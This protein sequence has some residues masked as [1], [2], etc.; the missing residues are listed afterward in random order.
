MVKA[1]DDMGFTSPGCLAH[2]LQLVVHDGVLSQRAVLDVLSICRRI[3]GH[4]KHSSLACGSLRKIQANLGLPIHTLKQDVPTRWNSTY[5]MLTSILEQKLALA[6]YATENSIPN[7]TSHQL[8]LVSKVVTVLAPVEEITQMISTEVAPVSVLIPLVRGLMKTLEKHHIN[9]SGVRTMKGEMLVSLKRRFADMEHKEYLLLAI[10]LD[11]R[12]KNKFFSNTDVAVDLLEQKY[13]TLL[14]AEG[15]ELPLVTCQPEKQ[16]ELWASFTEILEESGVSIAGERTE[17]TRYLDEP[18]INTQKGNPYEWW[19][20]NKT[21]YPLLAQLAR[22]YLSTP[23]TSV[24]SERLFSSAGEIYDER[25]NRLTP[26]NAETL[27]FIKNNFQL[28]NG[29]Y[30]Y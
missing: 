8:D 13:C 20:D 9:D 29:Q 15:K 18:L 27:L 30:S 22:K 28:L 2:T 5:Y 21:R 26:K 3:V 25:R 12:Y 14:C 17:V 4:F 23:P 10:I 11:P 7:L 16:S 1:I 24:P 6:A 19:R